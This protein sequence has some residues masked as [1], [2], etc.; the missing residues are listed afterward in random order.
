MPTCICEDSRDSGEVGVVFESIGL[1]DLSDNGNIHALTPLVPIVFVFVL[2]SQVCS[3]VACSY[4]SA[5]S[6]HLM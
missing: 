6:A 5:E 1:I 4:C 3:I 2:H